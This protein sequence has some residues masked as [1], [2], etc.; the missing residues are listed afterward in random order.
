MYTRTT[1]NDLRALNSVPIPPYNS[2]TGDKSDS[3]GSFLP[4]L[5]FPFFFSLSLSF[6]SFPLFLRLSVFVRTSSFVSGPF[7]SLGSFSLDR[8]KIIIAINYRRKSRWKRPPRRRLAP[9]ANAC[10]TRCFASRRIKPL[11]AKRHRTSFNGFPTPFPL[12]TRWLLH[13]RRSRERRRAERSPS[14]RHASPR[15]IYR[16]ESLGKYKRFPASQ[17]SKYRLESCS[18]VRHERE[19]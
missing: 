5:H 6:L 14:R 13:A 18:Y 7:P 8:A 3:P 16:L 2:E 17:F 10:Q 1:R 19:R 15:A 12:R 11:L 9:L 4:P